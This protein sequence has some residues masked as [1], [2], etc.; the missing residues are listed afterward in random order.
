[1]LWAGGCCVPAVPG[2]PPRRWCSSA[3]ASAA[4]RLSGDGRRPGAPE[5]DA[6]H[7][8]R[9]EGVFHAGRQ[10]AG[11]GHRRRRV[12]VHRGPTPTR[13]GAEVVRIEDGEAGLSARTVKRRLASVTGP[14]EYLIVRG[15]VARNPVPHGLSTRTPSRAV[16]GVPLIR[17]PRTLPRVIDPDEADALMQALRTHRDRA[18]LQAMLLG[19]GV[20]GA[21][22]AAV[23]RASWRETVVHRRREG[24]APA[25]RAGVTAVLHHA[26]QLPGSRTAAPREAVA[27]CRLRCRR[28]Q[29]RG[30]ACSHRGVRSVPARVH[31]PGQPHHRGAR[32]AHPHRGHPWAH[33]GVPPGHPG[34]P[35]R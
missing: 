27:V 8:V 29:D 21:R 15:V 23:R 26:G 11:G 18:M 19:G 31:L 32:H 3:G 1:M 10:G 17:F 34:P 14:F 20:R 28:R 9:S 25:D 22:A 35:S 5:Y 6:G 16:R 33:P 7:G 30:R 24:R 12:V 4:R 2:S 13:R